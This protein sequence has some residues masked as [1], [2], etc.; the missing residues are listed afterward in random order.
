MDFRKYLI[1]L[2]VFLL[3]GLAVQP[4][5]SA[6]NLT[7]VLSGKNVASVTNYTEDLTKDTANQFYNYGAQSLNQGDYIAAIKYFDQALAGNTTM[8]KKT[9]ALL[10]TYQNKA[11][12]QIQLKQYNE[13]IATLDAGLA[14]YPKDPMLWNNRGYA[15]SLQGKQQDALKAYETAISFD[16]NYT[17]A[18]INQ[19][20]TLSQ[21]G[22]YSDAV[23]AYNRANE[24][25]PFN[26]AAYDGL[27]IAKKGEAGSSQTS[28]IL[29]IVVL[30]AAAAVVVWYIKFRKPAEPAQDGKKKRS[31]KKE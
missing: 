10:Y 17:K 9:D 20:D 7:D 12:S 27:Q 1:I 14:V 13:A 8:M 29:M 4:A 25:D 19:G 2:T 26:I 30:I 6:D 11:Y 18:Y 24:T 21:M 16:R 28:M 31:G 22:K 5:L 23:A 3:A 15:L